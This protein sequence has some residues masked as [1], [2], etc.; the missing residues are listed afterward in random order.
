MVLRTL[1]ISDSE[2]TVEMAK[3]MSGASFRVGF[4]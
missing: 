2:K 1:K 3:T 4:V